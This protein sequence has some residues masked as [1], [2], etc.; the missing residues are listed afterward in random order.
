MLNNN[1]PDFEFKEKVLKSALISSKNET[2]KMSLADNTFFPIVLV[3]EI[4]LKLKKNNRL[5]NSFP[6][7]YLL[8]GIFDY[9]DSV[10]DEKTLLYLESITNKFVIELIEKQ[11]TLKY[12]DQVTMGVVIVKLYK[13]NKNSKY[14]NACEIIINWLIN[15]ISPKYGIILYRP[16]LDY[17]YVDTLGMICPFLLLCATILD[18]SE[19]IE[20]SNKQIA[21]YINNGLN[22]DRIPF[23]AIDLKNKNTPM[24]SCN[25]GRGMGWYLLAI[26]ATLKYTNSNNNSSYN[27]FVKELNLLKPNLNKF[28]KNHYWGQFLGSSK[29]W[30]IDTSVSCMLFYSL[31]LINE[32][33][34]FNNFYHFIKP[35]TTKKGDVDYTSGDTEDINLYSREYN[36]SELTQGLLLSIF[37]NE[38]IL[39]EKN[40]N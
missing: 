19:L 16:Y 8:N 37:K 4:N 38:I 11:N 31:S 3:R 12:I 17:Q 39:H 9:A 15:N 25:W 33:I 22:D 5:K 21:F 7:G 14:K 34:D 26:S 1:T 6:K 27:L 13:K 24:G 40:F 23:H 35:L 36:K 20:L 29:N 30:H 28:K 2:P 32:E 10:N 18:K